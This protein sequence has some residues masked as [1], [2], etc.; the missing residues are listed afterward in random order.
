MFSW[1]K[2]LSG[3]PEPLPPLGFAPEFLDSDSPPPG[4]VVLSIDNDDETPMEFVVQVLREYCGLPDKQAVAVM[5][6]V[7]T[8]GSADVRT[9]R[10]SDAQKLLRR[11]S[12]EVD[13]RG[14]PLR[15]TLKS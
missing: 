1:L 6:K 5:L 3:W 14:F 9:M 12:E 2:N 10:K 7:H 15:C 11:I 4:S 13:K 8:D